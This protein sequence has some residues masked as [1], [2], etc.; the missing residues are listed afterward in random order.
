MLKF[1]TL[2]ETCL[3]S[4][5]D[6]KLIVMSDL[7]NDATPMEVDLSLC[8]LWVWVYYLLIKYHTQMMLETIGK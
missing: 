8:Q 3:H 5:F 2:K 6:W 1:V 4:S 7:Q